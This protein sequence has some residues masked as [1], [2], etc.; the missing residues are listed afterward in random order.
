MGLGFS[1]PAS[2]VSSHPEKGG[3]PKGSR[4]K[5]KF[6]GKMAG[7]WKTEASRFAREI[8]TSSEYMKNLIIRAEAGI[9][10]PAVEIMLWNYSF[11]KPLDRTELTVKDET[12]DYSNYSPAQLA[13]EAVQLGQMAMMLAQESKKELEEN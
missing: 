12:P 9:L 11:G 4:N 1:S 5:K 7:E 10:P 3:R 8:I 2:E 6:G 13:Q